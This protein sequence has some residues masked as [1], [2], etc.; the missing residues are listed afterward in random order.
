MKNIFCFTIFLFFFLSAC[1][2]VQA[3]SK[4]VALKIH[5][6]IPPS[7]A[8]QPAG[9]VMATASS[10]TKQEMTVEKTLRNDHPVILQSVAMK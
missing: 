6:R 5:V 10:D 3:A 2:P 7:V 1:L 8:S 4:S 9:A